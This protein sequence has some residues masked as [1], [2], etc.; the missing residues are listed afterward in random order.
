MADILYNI[1]FWGIPCAALA[2]YLILLLFFSISK[3]DRAI[4]AFQLILFALALW[5]ASSLLM[6]MNTFPSPLFWN[7]MMMVGVLISPFFIYLF[8]SIFTDTIH[9]IPLFLFASVT[10]LILIAD[11]LGWVVT[12]ARL[13]YVTVPTS[14]GS[15]VRTEFDYQIGSWAVPS[16]VLMFFGILLII[17]M[18]RSAIKMHKADRHQMYPILT[19]IIL[20][21]LGLLGNLL[22]QVG[23]YPVDILAALINGLLI[24]Y[25]IY[26]NRMLEMKFMLTKG[27]VFTAFT[28]LIMGGYLI[29]ASHGQQMWL[30]Q[31]IPVKYATLVVALITALLFQ[32][33]LRL[34][35]RLTNAVFFKSEYTRR[36]ALKNFSINVSNNLS[37]DE[38]SHQFIEAISGAMNPKRTCLLLRDEETGRYVTFKSLQK[39]NPMEASMGPDSP[40]VRWLEEKNICL[41][42]GEIKN[43][44]Q[45]RALWDEELRL[46]RDMEAEILVPMQCRNQLVGIVLLTEKRNNITYTM[47]DLDLLKSFGASTAMA[48]SNALM[49]ERVQK[50]AYTDEMTGLYNRKYFHKYLGEQMAACKESALS[51]LVLDLD[52]F[53]LYN[54]LYGFSEGDNAIAKT[55]EI[56]E[57]C[58]DRRGIAARYSGQQFMA[59]LPEY[60]TPSATQVAE[61]I[62]THVQQAFFDEK[63]TTK[64]FLTISV[65]VCTYPICAASMTE[66]IKRGNLALYNAKAN[67]KNMVAI[68]M[69]QQ[70]QVV[71]QPK[72][73]EETDNLR[74]TVYALTAAIDAKDHYTFSHSL[75]VAKYASALARRLQLDSIHQEVVYEA[76]LLHD[77]GKIGIPENILTKTTRLSKDEY[78]II[79]K[80]VDIS[81]NIVKHLPNME[82]VIPAIV[83]HHERWDGKGYPRGIAGELIPIEA[84]CLNIADTFDAITSIRPYKKMLSVEYAFNELEKNAGTQFD[85][86]LVREFVAMIRE[87]EVEVTPTV[88]LQQE[89][90]PQEMNLSFSV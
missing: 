24:F 56:I 87:K 9:P 63:S 39:L 71:P 1:I 54:E 67:G 59:V 44:V 8:L 86:H 85:P 40:I 70:T 51:I 48:L 16:Y 14:S 53:K 21:F 20:V 6:K 72:T 65:G 18:A 23:K 61:A 30:F 90:F 35:D 52:R 46:L 58:L 73:E 76:G 89:A 49:F 79:Q 13:V 83:G 34:A 11:M 60:D 5:T 41:T 22:P 15:I 4:R 17:H 50:D 55:A 45:F 78:Q 42:M 43:K 10:V 68:Y 31:I 19:G 74:S 84:R 64:Q 75:N 82:H 47:D 37:L 32:P 80:H 28:L 25:A 88:F 33:A 26:R 3:K 62:R 12:D 81:I 7:K 27:V 66:L 29:F 36:N 38:I 2:T 57:Q 77:V 69:P